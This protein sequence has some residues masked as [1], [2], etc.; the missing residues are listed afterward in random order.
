MAHRIADIARRLALLAAIATVPGGI[1]NAAAPVATG[2]DMLA[3]ITSGL[4]DQYGRPLTAARLAGKFVL[5]NFIFT[6]CGSTCPTQTAELAKFDASLPPALRARL[7]IVSISVDPAND[8]PAVLKRYASL[9]HADGRRWAF[10]TGNPARLAQIARSFA[11]FR[12]GDATAA[13]HTSDVRLFDPRHRMIQRY[14][15]APLAERQLRE[16][17]TTLSASAR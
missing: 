14:A 17:L 13:F 4:V 16:D 7:A 15:A 11:A 10:V 12:P 3:P 1:V 8:T 9:F 6:G 2:Q 5:V